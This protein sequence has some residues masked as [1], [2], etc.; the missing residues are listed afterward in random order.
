M[1]VEAKYPLLLKGLSTFGFPKL[2]HIDFIDNQL[3]PSCTHEGIVL[4]KYD[5]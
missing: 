1:S 2:A 5:L 4:F 3:L